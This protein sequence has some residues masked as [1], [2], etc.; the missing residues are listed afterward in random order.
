[1]PAASIRRS[2]AFRSTSAGKEQKTWPQ[3]VASILW[4]TGPVSSRDLPS[5]RSGQPSR[6]ACSDIQY[7]LRQ[8]WLLRS[9][10]IL[11]NLFSSSIL[12]VSISKVVLSA[13]R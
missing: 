3:R 4:K 2:K 8:D 6:A 1:M 10:R 11:S 7:R 13:L 9:T 12:S 5:G